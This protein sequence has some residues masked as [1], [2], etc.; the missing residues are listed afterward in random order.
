MK[1]LLVIGIVLF[2]AALPSFASSID[3]LKHF[4]RTT[5]SAQAAFDQTV[6]DQK[7]SVTRETQ[8]SMVFQRPGKFRWT[9][10]KPFEQVIVGDG[11]KLWVFDKELNQVTVKPLG[12]ALGS[13]PA[14]LLAGSNEIERSFV[15]KDL[16]SA[17]G[18]EWLE[19]TPKASESSFKSIRMGF[20]RDTLSKMEF[21]DYFGQ[22]TI[23]NFRDFKRNVKPAP[24]LFSFSPPPGADI[25]GE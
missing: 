18:L 10:A 5:R 7:L 13:S 15:L 6:L 21:R 4:V 24:S 14:A 19:A 2:S 12:D 20:R 9:Y 8:G 3:R 17:D 22:T 23:L 16:G 25:I 1:K 11:A